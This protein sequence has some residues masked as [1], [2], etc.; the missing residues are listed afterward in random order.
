MK[1]LSKQDVI[2]SLI[3]LVVGMLIG[4]FIRGGCDVDERYGCGNGGQNK[5]ADYQININQTHAYITT[6]DTGE[7]Q[8]VKHKELNNRNKIRKDI[9]N[10]YAP[11]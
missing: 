6:I 9:Y 3:L 10:R 11:R 5:Q 8:K 4:W 7:T 2:Y 1:R